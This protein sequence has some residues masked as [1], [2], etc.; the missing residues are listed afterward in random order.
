MLV[1]AIEDSGLVLRCPESWDPPIALD[2][3][4]SQSLSSSPASGS[5][6]KSFFGISFLSHRP[7]GRSLASVFVI[8]TSSLKRRDLDRGSTPSLTERSAPTTAHGIFEFIS[9]A[10]PDSPASGSRFSVWLWIVKSP[11]SPSSLPAIEP[12]KS[13]RQIF[14]LSQAYDSSA[15]SNVDSTVPTSVPESVPGTTG[16]ETT[17]SAASATDVEFYCSRIT[18]SFELMVMKR[19][20]LFID[21]KML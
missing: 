17:T 10:L 12:R 21:R 18:D 11:L 4:S 8:R 13:E 5:R 3:E 6:L 2:S 9:S 15:S 19:T 20:F 1:C 16:R 14:Q 7:K